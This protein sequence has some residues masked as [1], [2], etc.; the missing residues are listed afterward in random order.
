MGG[1]AQWSQALCED[2]ILDTARRPE[3]DCIVRAAAIA[4]ET[5]IAFITLAGPGGAPAMPASTDAREAK[6]FRAAAFYARA[7]NDGRVFAV[8][9]AHNDPR[10]ANSPLVTG[11]P[12]IR[13]Y[14]EAP[15]SDASGMV[16]GRLC[17]AD[18]A[19]RVFTPE[20]ETLLKLLAQTAINAVIIHSQRSLLRRARRVIDALSAPPVRPDNG[21][22]AGPAHAN[23]A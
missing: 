1:Q 2:R 15:M 21:T 6:A 22:A 18:H 20:N 17:I 14:A 8:E 11:E 13:F 23:A 3:F 12:F 10:F 16:L 9:D 19:A 5:P 7:I 4:F